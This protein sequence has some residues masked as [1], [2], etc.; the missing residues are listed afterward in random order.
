[1]AGKETEFFVTDDG[2]RLH[3]K[4]TMPETEG[5]CPLVIVVHGYTGHMEEDH[6]A[7]L[8]AP[9]TEAGYAALR[10]E[11][12][13]HGQSDG[14]FRNH[15]LYKWVS[16]L[17]T[18]T[19]YARSLDFVTDLYLCGHSQGGLLVML[20]AGMCPDRFKAVIPLSPAWM[21][22]EYARNGEILGAGIDPLNIPETFFQDEEHELSGNYVRVA[23]T[24]HPEEEIVRYHGPVLIV[25]GDADEVVPY[26]YG[27]KAAELYDH[28]TL[29]PIPG[30]DHCFT[31][32][33]PMVTEAV[34][35]F[36]TEQKE[37]A[38]S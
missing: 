36:L 15:T 4:L 34:K 13:G 26:S 33:F 22:P 27:Q 2:I 10:V 17:L 1:M 29:I 21:I 16:N 9:I 28:A 14:K 12:Y 19:E 7:G 3:A 24:I 37:K 20:V 8:V 35:Q 25:H 23:Q 31:V 38:V 6:I 11:M 32:H 5:K 30:D 18:V